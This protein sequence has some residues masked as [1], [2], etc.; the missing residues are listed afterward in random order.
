MVNVVEEE[1][2]CRPSLIVWTWLGKRIWTEKIP[3]Y[4]TPVYFSVG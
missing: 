2:R 3:K 4:L 1:H